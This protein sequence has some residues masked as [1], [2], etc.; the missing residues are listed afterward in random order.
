[1]AD[2]MLTNIP[3]PRVDFIDPRTGLMAREWYRF[4]LNLFTLTG[5][6]SNAVSLSDLQVGPPA[7]ANSL[8][9]LQAQAS[10]LEA[11][12][13][14]QDQLAELAKT[15]QGMA[16]TPPPPLTLP[17][18]GPGSIQ[19]N[20]NGTFGGSVKFS[21]DG[22]AAVTVGAAASG[23]SS[24]IFS[25]S[26]AAGTSV[27]LK[28]GSDLSFSGG[29]AYSVSGTG[30]G[31]ALNFLGGAGGPSGI[32]GQAVIV[33]GDGQNGGD[34]SLAAGNS[35]SGTGV[36]GNFTGN[37][38]NSVA[39]T[40]GNVVW[41]PGTGVNQASDGTTTFYTAQFVPGVYIDQYANVTL[42]TPQTVASLI[43][44]TTAG[45]GARS[46]VTDALAPVFGNTVV[47]GGAVNVPVYSD[48]TNWKVG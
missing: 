2:P 26:G 15:V 47:G 42:S 19:Y 40:G 16:L 6:G 23:L 37:A 12:P 5:N 29:N 46:F 38:G 30:A 9:A 14:Y 7:D 8:V 41:N 22:S 45:A 39:G 32:G 28:N 24:T 17:G 13:A 34:A 18:D 3:A 44:A 10:A 11:N 25:F 21:Y 35:I 43:S 20:N 48:G 1:M 31:G 27:T 4:F 36:G 33:G